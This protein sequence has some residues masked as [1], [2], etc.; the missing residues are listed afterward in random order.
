MLEIGVGQAAHPVEI[1]AGAEVLAFGPQQQGTWPLGEGVLMVVDQLVEAV[2]QPQH[3]RRIEGV[4]A[5]GARQDKLRQWAMAFQPKTGL[6]QIA[7]EG[8]GHAELLTSGR[9]RIVL[10]QVRR[11]G[12]PPAPGPARCGSGRDR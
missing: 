3:Q 8:V 12:R 7:K 10:G 1:G 9:C 2:E 5:G 4:V 11:P 6:G